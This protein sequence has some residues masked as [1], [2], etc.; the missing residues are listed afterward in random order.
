[1]SKIILQGT[2]DFLHYSFYLWAETTLN[3]NAYQAHQ[4]KT[5]KTKKSTNSKQLKASKKQTSNNYA[6]LPHPYTVPTDQLVLL[7]SSMFED[8]FLVR[9]SEPIEFNLLL[10]TDD[11]GPICSPKIMLSLMKQK[12]CED[13]SILNINSSL[14]RHLQSWQVPCIRVN[15]QYLFDLLLSI[16]IKDDNEDIEIQ[17]IESDIQENASDEK[18]I[19]KKFNP[20]IIGYGNSLRYWITCAKIALECILQDA[21][22]LEIK[23]TREIHS[24]KTLV[25]KAHFS[26]L[27]K[28]QFFC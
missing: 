17:E 10:P 11:Q 6:S 25:W 8:N 1:M 7:L 5:K 27:I 20:S 4:R 24:S 16:P 9:H 3:N 26:P 23:N 2:W 28:D 22:F 13:P 14:E 15:N 19:I 21:Y 18:G 12:A